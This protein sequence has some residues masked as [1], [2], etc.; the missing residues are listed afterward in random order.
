MSLTLGVMAVGAER[1]AGGLV[2]VRG[3]AVV[4]AWAAGARPRASGK[5]HVE[6]LLRQSASNAVQCRSFIS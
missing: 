3:G 5:G 2:V 4:R 1:E 6:S